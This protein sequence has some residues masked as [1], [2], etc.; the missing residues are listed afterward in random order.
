[1]ADELSIVSAWDNGKLRVTIA[2]GA[3]KFVDRLDPASAI[4]RARFLKLVREQLPAVPGAELERHLLENAEPPKADAAA[5]SLED[6][7]KASDAALEQMPADIR[8]EADEMLRAPDLLERLMHDLQRVGIV[9]EHALA[10]TIYLQ[11]TSRLLPK[12]V[13]SI[14]QGASSSGKSH[15]IER[16]A[17]LFPGETTL[18]AT[19]LTPNAL[20]YLPRGSLRHRFVVAGERSRVEDDERA[21]ATRA[22]R[23]MIGSGVLRKVLPQ[24]NGD[25]IETIVIENPGP[26]AFIE[27]TTLAEIFEEDRNRAL[28]LASDDGD[29][30]TRA[31]VTAIAAH[32]AG[33]EQGDAD[34]VRLR[35][36]AVQRM[37][38]RVVVT[39]PFA[40]AL[41]ERVPT[42][43]PDARR[44]IHQALTVVQAVAVLHQFQRLE[45]PAHG[46]A[47]E[48][49]LADYRVARR[50]LIG[51]LSR[52]LGGGL[53]EHVVSFAHWLEQAAKPPEAWTV[54][55]LIGRTGC[56]WGRSQ[57]YDLS[58][59]LHAIGFLADAGME[60]RSAKHRVAGPLPEAGAT[61]LPEVDQLEAAQ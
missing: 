44:A 55:Q 14:V 19:D 57:I 5:S 49:T 45:E 1:M 37:L 28:L 31:V 53:P 22:M 26:I 6:P 11:G 15:V 33:T 48:A 27:S 52:A 8:A 39:V 29:E 24:K 59:P 32:Y 42:D 20:Y 23:E 36:H 61:W 51:P 13:S 17:S 10:L 4:S 2:N 38:R 58:K 46:A 9:G 12:P 25:V 50:L 43:R 56:R 47:M 41:A 35:H 40:P 60:G 7:S 54:A 18:L 30:Q 34:R 16:V 21:E 3:V